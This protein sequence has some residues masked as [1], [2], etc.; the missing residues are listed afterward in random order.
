MSDLQVWYWKA[1]IE[2]MPKRGAYPPSYE[3]TW[4]INMRRELRTTNDNGKLEKEI[5]NTDGY[6]FISKYMR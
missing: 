6:V 2:L 3:G 1:N 5:S 4:G